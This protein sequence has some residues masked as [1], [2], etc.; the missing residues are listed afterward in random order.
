MVRIENKVARLAASA[1]ACRRTG[2]GEG[3]GFVALSLGFVTG[4]LSLIVALPVA[5]L[6]WRRGGRRVGLL[7]RRLEAEV[8]AALKLTLAIAA[9]VALVD[10]VFGR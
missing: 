7:G 3:F 9:V 4:F 10:A 5:A 1:A 6:V 8:I 2:P